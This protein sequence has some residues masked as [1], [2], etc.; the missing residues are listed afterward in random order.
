M[1][2][3]D[4]YTQLAPTTLKNYRRERYDGGGFHITLNRMTAED[5]SLVKTL[6]QSLRAIY[7]IWLYMRDAPNYPLLQEQIRRLGTPDFL[8]LAR[9]LGRDTRDRDE[10]HNHEPDALTQ[11]A[12]HDIRGGG[13]TALTGYTQL[14]DR[15]SDD[16]LRQQYLQQAV[17]LAR[18]HAKMMRNILPDIDPTIREADEGLKLHKINEFVDKWRGFNFDLQQKQVSVLAH[19]DFTGYVTNRC[20]ETSAVDRILYNYINNAARFAASDTIRLT[21]IPIGDKLTRWVVENEISDDQQQWLTET[22]GGDLGKLFFGSFTRGGN[23][24]GLSN[25]TDLVAASFGIDNQQAIEGHYLG[26][27]VQAGTYY[28]WFHWPAYIPQSE[29]ELE[30]E[31][32]DDG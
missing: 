16:R 9:S 10:S 24:I 2:T 8:A 31:C 12:F 30:C 7:D 32:G 6:Y 23:G 15:I 27:E 14:I 4:I 19:S 5:A 29:D 11:K 21:V 1:T 20:L 18:D 22:L 13:L 28:A 3:P 25:C 17:Y 26:A